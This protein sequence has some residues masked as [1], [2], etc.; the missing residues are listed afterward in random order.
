M[1]REPQLDRAADLHPDRD[2]RPAAA[3]LGQDH[4]VSAATPGA[5]QPVVQLTCRSVGE[6]IGCKSISSRALAEDEGVRFVLAR[7]AETQLIVATRETNIVFRSSS[8]CGQ[9]AGRAGRLPGA[10]IGRG[11]SAPGDGAGGRVGEPVRRGTR[12]P[13]RRRA[14]RG[15]EPAARGGLHR[16][17]PQRHADA[18]NPHG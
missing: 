1:E 4:G 7:G 12:R 10:G 14:A 16:W 18:G 8:S 17:R 15:A 5:D 13:R 11:R 9:R 6:L 2:R 3:Q